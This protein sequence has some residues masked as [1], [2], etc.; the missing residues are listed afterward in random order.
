LRLQSKQAGRG[1][2]TAGHALC[3]AI[4]A[5]TRKSP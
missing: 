5:R 3:R 2:R 4:G 1:H